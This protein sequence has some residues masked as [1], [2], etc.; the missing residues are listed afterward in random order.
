MKILQQV[1]IVKIEVTHSLFC[2]ASII[3]RKIKVI[4]KAAARPL[5]IWKRESFAYFK[6]GHNDGAISKVGLANT[7]I[8]NSLTMVLAM[9]KQHKVGRLLYWYL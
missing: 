7:S 2:H 6:H 5:R 3:L 9:R 4:S 1:E 8:I